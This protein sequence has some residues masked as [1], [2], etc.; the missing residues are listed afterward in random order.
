MKHYTH[1]SE[2][3]KEIDLHERRHLI[4]TNRKYFVEIHRLEKLLDEAHM[5]N[6]QYSQFIHI[7]KERYP[8]EYKDI[9]LEYKK[10]HEPDHGGL[11][12]EI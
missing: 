10:S 6:G 9:V 5:R 8:S 3:R 11:P 4:L 2:G 1:Y 7:F 12:K